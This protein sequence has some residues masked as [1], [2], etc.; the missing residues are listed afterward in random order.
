MGLSGTGKQVKRTRI[1]PKVK[2]A[3]KSSNTHLFALLLAL[4]YLA[5]GFFLVSDYGIT[6]D[7][8]Q[9]FLLGHKYLYFYHTGQLNLQDDTPLIPYH[10]NFHHDFSNFVKD[11]PFVLF[12]FK[13]ILSAMTC[14]VFFQLFDVMG[15]IPAHHAVIPLLVA[16]LLYFLFVFVA[17]NWGNFAALAATAALAT[18]PRFFSDGLS[19]IKDASLVVFYSITIIFFAEYVMGKKVKYFYWACV[20][21][22]FTLGSKMNGLEIPAILLPWLLPG[23]YRSLKGGGRIET[24]F[25]PRALLGFSI[26]CAIIV[27]SYPPLLPWAYGS[28]SEFLSGAGRCI[29]DTLRDIV[30][31]GYNP[32]ISWNLYAFKQIFYVTPPVMLVFFLAGAV[33]VFREGNNKKLLLLLSVWMLFGPLRHCLPGANHY[34]GVKHFI[35]FIVPFSVF[36]AFGA[37]YL[38]GLWQSWFPKSGKG[39]V[40]PAI[41][42]LLLLPNIYA[43]ASYHPYQAVYYSELVG[44]IKGAQE[45]GIS[46]SFEYT[47]NSYREAALWLNRNAVRDAH[48]LAV[49]NTPN[50]AFFITR[51]DLSSNVDP[52][53]LQDIYY[54]SLENDEFTNKAADVFDPV[55]KKSIRVAYRI[56]RRGAVLLTIYFSEGYSR[57]ADLAESRRRPQ[58]KSRPV[59]ESP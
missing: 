22:A 59:Q 38:A 6:I 46:W 54:I 4:A 3:D 23:A 21:W 35:T 50:L 20:F 9:D 43:L 5:I 13:N 37:E 49:R 47:L 48:Y 41:L 18:Y 33:R 10:P 8:P 57:M 45:K 12:P 34:S 30:M 17:R 31:I 29:H 53:S 55:M 14:Y 19:N 2:T 28:F 15:A 27:A 24:G 1:P 40:R 51:P 52:G 26:T 32:D 25:L 7:E 16:L 58:V 39:R 42:A 36:C 56:E 11:S 44:G